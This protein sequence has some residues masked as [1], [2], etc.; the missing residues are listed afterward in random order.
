MSDII[1]QISELKKERQELNWKVK[2]LDQLIDE[3]VKLFQSQCEHE[4]VREWTY[5]HKTIWYCKK[6]DY[7]R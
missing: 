2:T 7:Y 6:C 1:D 5:G 4:Y 3:K